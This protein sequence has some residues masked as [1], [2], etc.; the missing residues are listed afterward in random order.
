MVESLRSTPPL[1]RWLARRLLLTVIVLWGAATLAFVALQLMPGN[2]ARLIAGA[3]S[4]T[5]PTILHE[6]RVEYGF[7]HSILDQYLI[8]LGHLGR[9][10]LGTSYQLGQSVVSVIGSQLWATVSMALGAAFFGF[11]LAI[12]LSLLF[13]GRPRT[14]GPANVFELICLSTPSFWIGMMLL[15]V[16]S[17]RLHWF[18]ALGNDGVGA[19]VLPCI[20]LGLPIAGGLALVMSEGLERALEQ[21]FVV[22]VRARGAGEGRVRIRHVMRH[23]ILPALTLSGWSL[24]QLLGGVVVVETVFARQGIGELVV[25]AVGGRDFPVIGG[26]VLL[27]TLTL[28]L[29]NTVMDLLYRVIDVRLRAVPL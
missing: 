12:V 23:A 29:I 18:P 3:E 2:Q 13:A 7:N 19:L 5:S 28:V 20:T 27:S 8:Y 10:Q 22:T 14:R 17:F 16:F 9:G 24:S 6:I 15:S 4:Q 21:P 26:I 1:V 11:T 25:N